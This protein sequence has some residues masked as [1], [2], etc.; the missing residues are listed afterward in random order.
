M[1]QIPVEPKLTEYLHQKAA[2][3][4]IPIHASFELTPVCN[5]ACRMCYVRMDRK[6]Q[7]SIAPL[8]SAA[9]W[10]ALAEEMKEQGLLFILLTG[11][12][13]FTHPEFREIVSGLQRKGFIVSVNTNGTMIDEAAV[14]WLKKTP[15]SRFNI[16]LYGAS[17]ETYARLCG[18]PDG[19][20]RVTRAIRLL[21]EAGMTVK[22]SVSATPH[23]AEDLEAIFAYCRENRL[24]V[25]GTS[26]MFPSMR[27]DETCVGRNDRFTPEEAAYYS[28]KIVTL[29]NGEEAFLKR[30][31][32]G[33]LPA[34]VGDPDE[35]CTPDREGEGEGMRCRAGS[36]SGWVTWNGRLTICGMIP[37]PDAPDVFEQGFAGAWK[38]LTAKAA[39]IRLPAACR[40]CPL[41][42][43][44]HPCAAMSYTETG[45][46][47]KV[48][49]YRCRMTHAY[50]AQALRLA[51]EIR[52]KAGEIR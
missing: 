20:T 35:N 13:P 27:R 6:T 28:A 10:L 7:E 50:R 52:N 31:E 38:Q 16:T 41:K 17:D 2:V 24:L 12:E 30:V 11:G 42:E 26:Y 9:E 4:K 45:E 21:K 47:G 32:A 19:F 22:I 40:E 8:R 43:E 44:C 29:L 23:N 46:Y 25:Q 51:E 37:D 18:K 49:E 33:E 5:M 1:I 14:E 15:P 48:P 34:P 39:A 3:R 36:C